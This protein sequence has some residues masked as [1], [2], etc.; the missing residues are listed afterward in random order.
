MVIVSG[1][2]KGGSGKT[3]VAVNMAI[4]LANA[5][6]DVLLVDADDQATATTFTELR[7]QRNDVDHPYTCMQLRGPMVRAQV[8]RQR[9]KYDHIVIDTGGRDTQSQRA[10]LS[11][12]DV[13]LV[14]FLPRSFDMWTLDTLAEILEEVEPLNP[15]LRVYFFLNRADHQGHDNEDAAAM[16]EA[17]DVQMGEYVP[18]PLYNRKIFGDA[19]AAGLGVTE[20]LARTESEHKAQQEFRSLYEF[21]VSAA[22]DELGEG[23]GNGR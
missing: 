9:S 10:A 3:T 5:G 6:G 12:A 19:A 15:E 7:E 2:I 1:G 17:V 13:M 20:M 21:V 8:E 22:D 11:V 16:L 23:D 18:R 14:P 4:E